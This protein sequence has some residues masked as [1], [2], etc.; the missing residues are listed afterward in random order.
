MSPHIHIDRQ[1]EKDLFR[2][3]LTGCDDACILLIEAPSGLGKTLLMLEYQRIARDVGVR[4]AVLDLRGIGG[5]VSE[6]I[7][8]ICEEWAD[9]PFEAFRGCVRAFQHPAADVAVHGVIQI[10]RPQIQ[11]AINTPDETTRRERQRQLTEALVADLRDWLQEQGPGVLLID[12]YN[13]GDPV[14]PGLQQWV[15][16]VL[17]PHVRRT[18]GLYVVLAGQHIPEQSAM[19][20][21]ACRRHHLQPLHNPADWMAYVEAEGIPADIQVVSAFCHANGGHPLKLAMMLSS[22]RS[23]GGGS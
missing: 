17:L 20:E 19:W 7:A 6:V 11:V 23:W 16:G 15:E 21:G 5:V 1:A 12:T 2:N 4:Y 14:T 9:C 3:F 10:G 13:P 8:T 18:P 22:L